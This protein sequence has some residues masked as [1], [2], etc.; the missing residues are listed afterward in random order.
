MNTITLAPLQSGRRKGRRTGTQLLLSLS[1][2]VATM[3]VQAGHND[4]RVNLE[5]TSDPPTYRLGGGDKF[6]LKN[7]SLSPL[8]VRSGG[9]AEFWVTDYNPLLYKYNETDSLTT[10]DEAKA[11]QT[12]AAAVQKFTGGAATTAQ[13]AASAGQSLFF[14]PGVRAQTSPD[15]STVFA[16]C[17][18]IMNG[19]NLQDLEANLRVLN[20]TISD[21]IPSR[22]ADLATSSGDQL[23][24]HAN[25]A[26]AELQKVLGHG[27]GAD[28]AAITKAVKTLLALAN[29]VPNPSLYSVYACDPSTARR[30]A[31]LTDLEALVDTDTR[32]ALED[33][34]RITRQADKI[35]KTISLVQSMMPVLASVGTPFPLHDQKA[36]ADQFGTVTVSVTLN[37]D[38]APLTDS[39]KAIATKRTGTF[40]FHV[41]SYQFWHPSISA[42]AIYSFV[43]NP[44]YSVQSNSSNQLAIG[45]NTN[46]YNKLSGAVA[47][48]LT[49]DWWNDDL[50]KPHLQIGLIPDSDKLAFLA[51]MGVTAGSY[52]EF[53]F[54]AIYQKTSALAA[55]L[56][57]GQVVQS[58]GAL[59][60]QTEYKAG[61]YIGVGVK[62]K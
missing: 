15:G 30:A 46:D 42:A 59:K 9:N 23:A 31:S 13:P 62:L 43:R 52:V 1:T 26:A 60:T 61:L 48:N 18:V 8:I 47:L 34:D 17:P 50:L 25:T 12:F 11:V 39:A 32:L 21:D 41:D 45:Q 37:S 58:T 29:E 20:T 57:I 16:S 14:Q 27:G 28:L 54:G 49:P 55:G 2:L 35:D 7:K 6:S 44:T 38:F 10:T 19:I 36:V 56:S 5:L 3:T 33:A 22:I 24:T 40:I 4:K 51:G 53:N